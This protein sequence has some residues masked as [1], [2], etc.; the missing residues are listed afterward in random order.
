MRII[1]ATIFISLLGF[2]LSLY[3]Q[4]EDTLSIV[5]RFQLI[6]EQWHGLEPTLDNYSGFRTYCT[7]KSYRTTVVNV[8]KTIHHYDTTIIMKLNDPTYVVDKKERKATLR[9]IQKFETKYSTK[10]FLKTLNREC[11]EWKEIEHDRKITKNDFGER[12]YDGQRLILEVE[13]SKY[14]KNVT[15]IIDHINKHIHHLNLDD[16]Q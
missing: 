1:P 7:N 8:M 14:A 4:S 16:I 5:D 13:L 6:D 9:Q 3:G 10:E 2:Q 12:S 11:K 15:K